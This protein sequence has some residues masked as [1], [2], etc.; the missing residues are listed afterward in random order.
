MD[1]SVDRGDARSRDEGSEREPAQGD[2]ERGVEDLE[3]TTQDRGAG[4]H[5][6][7]LRVAVARWPALDDVRD[8]H[9][10]AG[11]LDAPE[12]LVEDAASP[13]DERLALLILVESRPLTDEHDL[14][15][16][17]SLPRHGLRPG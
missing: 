10:G 1:R 5:L 16:G 7:G 6:V 11:P 9:V 3:L 12:Q 14:G 17:A 2:D 15:V 4:R 13:A 8:E